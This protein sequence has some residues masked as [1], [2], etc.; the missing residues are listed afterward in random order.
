MNLGIEQHNTDEGNVTVLIWNVDQQQGSE[1]H[2]ISLSIVCVKL[3]LGR[4]GIPATGSGKGWDVVSGCDGREGGGVVL[5][6]GSFHC[7]KKAKRWERVERRSDFGK[8]L[9]SWEEFQNLQKFLI[10]SKVFYKWGFHEFIDA[11]MKPSKEENVIRK[12][13]IKLHVFT[14][15]EKVMAF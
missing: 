3:E 2:L 4:E 1:Y 10:E 11:F 5:A 13:W 7:W 6:S 15:V 14:H 12:S 9:L 8:H